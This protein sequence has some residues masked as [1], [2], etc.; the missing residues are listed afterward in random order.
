MIPEL[1][2]QSHSLEQTPLLM[3]KPT[4]TPKGQL[5]IYEHIESVNLL[6]NLTL[7]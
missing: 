5:N 7:I 1:F 3:Q 4:E 6:L 2:L